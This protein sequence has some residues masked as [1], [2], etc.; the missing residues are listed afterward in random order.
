MNDLSLSLL[1]AKGVWWSGSIIR[2]G[3]RERSERAACAAE[4]DETDTALLRYDAKGNLLF[5][6]FLCLFHLFCNS[7]FS[8]TPHSSL[9]LLF[10]SPLSPLVH[11]T[12]FL[13]FSSSC[14]SQSLVGFVR[15][16]LKDPVL[17]RLDTESTLSDRLLLMFFNVRL[18]DKPAALVYL[19][20]N[21]ISDVMKKNVKNSSLPTERSPLLLFRKSK[22]LFLLRL[23]ITSSFSLTCSSNAANS[24]SQQN[25][26]RRNFFF[27]SLLLLLLL[28]VPLVFRQRV[29]MAP[30]IKPRESNISSDS[31][32]NK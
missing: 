27:S 24:S 10:P 6:I 23:V 3:I 16:G 11:L 15:A 29:S 4:R 21:V 8:S 19:F 22:R 31:E 13:S 1:F 9:L 26:L 2:D 7:A 28:L 32:R 25:K 18:E 12:L 20:K 5:F 14:S 30:W 17:I